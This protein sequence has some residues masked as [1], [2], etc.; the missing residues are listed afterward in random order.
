MFKTDDLSNI[1]LYEIHDS[2]KRI[3]IEKKNTSVSC[4]LNMIT[5]E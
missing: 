1:E 4:Y 5:T 2:R 3:G